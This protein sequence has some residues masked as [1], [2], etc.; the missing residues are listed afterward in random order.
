MPSTALVGPLLVGDRV[1][2]E[3]GATTTGAHS[4]RAVPGRAPKFQRASSSVRLALT[5]LV[6]GC[7]GAFAWTHWGAGTRALVQRTTLLRPETGSHQVQLSRDETKPVSHTPEPAKDSPKP[8]IAPVPLSGV[9][10]PPRRPFAP[11]TTEAALDEREAIEHATDTR[12]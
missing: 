4:I 9:R 11:T 5:L 12:L 1:P 2:D 10:S 7:L 3:M 8:A 6:A